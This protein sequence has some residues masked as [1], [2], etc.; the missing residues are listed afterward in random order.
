MCEDEKIGMV[1]PRGKN[2]KHC[3]GKQVQKPPNWG[4]P[5]LRCT[6]Q[7]FAMHDA[8]CMHKLY[9]GSVKHTVGDRHC[10]HCKS[11]AFV[12]QLTLH[13]CFISGHMTPKEQKCLAK[14]AF[15]IYINFSIILFALCRMINPNNCI[16]IISII[17]I[18][19][20]TTKIDTFPTPHRS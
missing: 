2:G 15:Q 3:L 11:L 13:S 20:V 10:F 4:C 19:K 9:Q 1:W 5:N 16:L 12:F 18:I 6:I 8:R 14:N 17:A 7:R